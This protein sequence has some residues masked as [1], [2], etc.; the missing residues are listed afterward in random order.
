MDEERR[1]AGEIGVDGRGERI[2][3]AFPAENEAG[4]EENHATCEERVARFVFP[5]G[6]AGRG[7]IGPGREQRRGLRKRQARVAQPQHQRDGE[8]AAGRIAG[9][10]DR[11]SRS[12]REE[13]LVGREDVIQRRGKDMFGREP[14]GR[15][16]D[17]EAGARETPRDEAEERGRADEET[18]AMQIDERGDG[19]SRRGDPVGGDVRR[20]RRALL[21]KKTG[22]WPAERPRQSNERFEARLDETPQERGRAT[23]R[24]SAL[25]HGL[26]GGAG[27]GAAALERKSSEGSTR[28]ASFALSRH[29]RAWARSTSTPRPSA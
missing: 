4:A 5:H 13:R 10:H 12:G 26:A 20:E 23:R 8:A 11:L 16:E 7:E 9:E 19:L 17:I 22:E 1:Q 29:S 2:A 21:R 27:F 15:R 6:G 3:S 14:I 25:R 28:P 24:A 18:A